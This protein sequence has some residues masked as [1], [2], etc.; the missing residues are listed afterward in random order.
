M[1]A[2]NV[3]KELRSNSQNQISLFKK[4]RDLQIE[5]DQY[6]KRYKAMMACGVD[7]A[8]SNE[9][10]ELVRD[11]HVMIECVVLTVHA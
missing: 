1:A 4:G 7:A 8:Q 2:D 9:V 11:C 3:E 5:L 10:G 6:L